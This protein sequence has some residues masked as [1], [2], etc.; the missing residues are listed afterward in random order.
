MHTG[1]SGEHKKECIAKGHE[2]DLVPSGASLH[3]VPEE[4]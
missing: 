2:S 4:H 3:I 1:K